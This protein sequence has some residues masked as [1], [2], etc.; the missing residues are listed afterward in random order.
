MNAQEVQLIDSGANERL[1]K[2]ILNTVAGLYILMVCL[3][4]QLREGEA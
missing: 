3:K 4:W 1:L 2:L